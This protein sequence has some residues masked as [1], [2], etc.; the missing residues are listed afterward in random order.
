[1][2]VMAP[3]VMATGRFA[4]SPTGDL[5]VGNLRTALVAWL[6][7]RA[8]GGRFLV[9][10]EDLDPMVARAEFEAQHLHDLAAIGLDWDGEVV[11]QSGRMELY[12]AAISSLDARG[13]VYPCFCSRKEIQDAVRA[14]NGSA[15]SPEGA[16]P[17][18]CAH[19]STLQRSQRA[20]S[21]GGRPP[22]LR[23]RSSGEVV[24]VI[25]GIHGQ[26][27]AVVDDLVLRRHDGIPAYNLAVVVDDGDQGVQQVVRADDLLASTPRQAYLAGLLGLAPLSYLHIPLVLGPTGQRLAKRDGAVTL[28]ARL[29]L[30]ESAVDV[31]SA[32]AA[33]LGLCAPGERPTLSELVATF[34]VMVDAGT[35]PRTPWVFP[36]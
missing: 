16:Y 20:R 30:G 33:S 22:A 5:H 17:G 11:H 9:R 18:T 2:V 28:A 29:M 14:P 10:M 15:P 12:Q 36:C 32:L 8:G 3:L 24:T 35:L 7:A 25:D 21:G 19:L 23:L 13:L 4:P 26:Y 6:A 31:R 1:M 27:S 34:S